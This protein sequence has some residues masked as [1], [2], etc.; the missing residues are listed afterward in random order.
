MST[1]GMTNQSRMKNFASIAASGRPVI[2]TRRLSPFARLINIQGRSMRKREE[3]IASGI[4]GALRSPRPVSAVYTQIGLNSAEAMSPH[5]LNSASITE[6]L[7]ASIW[8]RDCD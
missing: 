1:S 8:W 7:K 4:G 6:A 2:G 3:H 5:H